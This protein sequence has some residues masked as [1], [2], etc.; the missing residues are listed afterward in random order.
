MNATG[1]EENDFGK[2]SFEIRVICNKNNPFD[3]WVRERACCLVHSP[4]CKA[5][6]RA[7]LHSLVND[8]TLKAHLV[9]S[10]GKRSTSELKAELAREGKKS[11]ASL[12][13]ASFSRARQKILGGLEQ[14]RTLQYSLLPSLLEDVIKVPCYSFIVRVSSMTS[15][16][17][18]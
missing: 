5:Q 13:D 14:D 6:S 3:W 10:S 2:C 11:L 15:F 8:P 1:K 4:L 17:F 12:S 9:N 7:S 18:L 16:L